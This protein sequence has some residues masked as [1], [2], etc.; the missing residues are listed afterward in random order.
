VFY[1]T[2]IFY[3]VGPQSVQTVGI[4]AAWGLACFVRWIQLQ[5]LLHNGVKRAQ[6]Q[7]YL[8]KISEEIESRYRHESG[9]HLK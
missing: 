5:V 4:I 2:V 1:S 3:T 6:K 8:A 9:W 7:E